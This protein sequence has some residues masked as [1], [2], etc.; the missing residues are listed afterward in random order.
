MKTKTRMTK[1]Q[2]INGHFCRV[3]AWSSDKTHLPR[4]GLTQIALLRQTLCRNTR[5]AACPRL[6]PSARARRPVPGTTGANEP[7]SPRAVP[8]RRLVATH[9]RS[10]RD[11]PFDLAHLLK[12]S[13]SCV[14]NNNR[15]DRDEKSPLATS[16]SSFRRPNGA[17]MN[18]LV[19]PRYQTYPFRQLTPIGTGWT[20]PP[21][22]V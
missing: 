18:H 8:D 15:H 14:W 13:A 11:S 9:R 7:A 21:G 17:R 22:R 6:T 16:D 3:E 12:D 4:A 10:D 20:R 1:C 19:N 5:S 2:F